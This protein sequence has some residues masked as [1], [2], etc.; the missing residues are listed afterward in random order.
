MQSSLFEKAAGK[1][2]TA[3]EKTNNAAYQA[4]SLDNHTFYGMAEAWREVLQTMG[5][6]VVLEHHRDGTYIVF[7]R[8]IING[9][10]T[11]EYG[12]WNGDGWE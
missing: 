2:E 11:A 10:T 1:L 7:E 6:S 5:H 12:S 3:V 8:L 4:R 9:R